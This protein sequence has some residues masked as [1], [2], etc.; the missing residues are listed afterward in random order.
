MTGSFSLIRKVAQPLA[1]LMALA[2]PFIIWLGVSYHA[3]H[4]LLPL[5]ALLLLLRLGLAS[6]SHGPLRYIAQGAAL[7]GVTLC[8]A[9]YLLR[10]HQL[11]LWYPVVVNMV[12]LVIFGASLWRGMPLVE[13]IAR[14][15][16]PELPPEGVVYTRRVTQ[17]WCGFFIGNGAMALLTCLHGDMR[18]WTLWNGGIAYLLMGGLMAGEWLVRLRVIKREAR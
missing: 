4:W 8:L 1:A 15:R 10:E 7:A 14:L 5:M 17:V 12:M 6:K 16:E 9:S 11:L 3:L 13:R 18:L 2:W